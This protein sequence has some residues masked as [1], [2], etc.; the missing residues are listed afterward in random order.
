MNSMA[1]LSK[2]SDAD[3]QTI[4]GS[5]K[6]V[7]YPEGRNVIVEGDEGDKFYII[8]DGEV[9]CTKGG[10]EVSERLKRGDFFGELA[11][12]S[13]DKRAATVTSTMA[14][15][16]LYLGRAEFIRMLGP[17][18]DEIAAAAQAK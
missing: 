12:L 6:E 5:L 1:M 13:S 10:K 7:E 15:T 8:R 2:L 17:L 3:K 9:K 11:L 18:S 16:V 14:T 4:A